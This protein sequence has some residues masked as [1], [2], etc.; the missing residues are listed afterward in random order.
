MWW[1]FYEIGRSE[2]PGLDLEN[3]SGNFDNLTGLQAARADA[4][5]LNA[6]C[7]QSAHGLKVR[8][9]APFGSVVGMA[10]IISELGPFAAD[11]ATIGHNGLPPTKFR[12]ESKGAV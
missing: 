3:R 2:C 11:F 6:T 10:D 9:K 7:D 12:Y 8:V 4:D 5:A 1:R